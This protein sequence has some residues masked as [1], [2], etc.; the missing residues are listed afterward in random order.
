MGGSGGSYFSGDPKKLVNS[1]ASAQPNSEYEAECNQL[2]SSFLTA[3]NDRN[4][5]AISRHL[6]E[7]RKALEKEIDGTIDLR[8][9]GSVA[10]HTYVDGLSDIDSLVMLDSCELAD[11]PPREAKAYL[12]ERLRERFPKTEV[13][14]GQ[15]AVTVNFSDA[16]IQLLPAVSCADTVKISDERGSAWAEI[17]PRE[18]TRVLTE[19]NQR[20][21]GKVIPVVKLAKAI[22]ST[23]PEKHQISGYH[24]ESLAVEAFREYYGPLRPKEMLQHFFTEGAKRV[25]NPITDRTGQSV[26]VDDDLGPGASLERRILSDAFSRIARRMKNADAGARIDEWHNLFGG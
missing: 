20:N 2:L 19:V 8:Y 24:A 4:R 6:A 1:L 9:G 13:I 26:H 25:F 18:F 23:L 11:S 3:F 12:A 7:I 15:L 21:A 10:K 22:I 5:E 17:R 16:Q 14:E